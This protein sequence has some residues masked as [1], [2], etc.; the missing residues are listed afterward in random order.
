MARLL[1]NEQVIVCAFVWMANHAHLQLYS[2]DAEALRDFHGGLKKRITDFLKRLLGLQWLSVWDTGDSMAEILDLDKAIDRVAYTFLNPVR[3]KLC[4]SID[5]YQGFHTWGE[6]LS[7]PQ[8]VNACIEREVP[9]I[10]ATDIEPLSSENPSRREEQGLIERILQATRMRASQ[11]LRIYPFKWLEAFGVTDPM[12]IE[13]VRQRIIKQVRDV[14]AELAVS[15]FPRKPEGYV[16]TDAYLPPP[17]ERRVFMY[18]STKEIRQA[19]LSVF[20]SFVAAGRHCYQLMKQGTKNIPWPPE[21]FI[22]PAPKLCN[23]W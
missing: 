2:L 1:V 10:L 11:T 5:S 12:E 9:W 23:V 8:D 20:R 18:G 15:S 7:A 6:F 14:E 19:H 21:C 16:V 3:A 17:K 22:P 13:S 4:R